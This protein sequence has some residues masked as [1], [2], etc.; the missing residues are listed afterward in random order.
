MRDTYTAVIERALP[1]G[2]SF[3]SE[4]YETGWADEV[5]VFVKVRNG[6]DTERTLQARVQISP[7]GVDW[8][9]FGVDLPPLRG[10]SMTFVT[11]RGFGNWLRVAGTVDAP[12]AE[13]RLSIYL[14]LKG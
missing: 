5:T 2:S 1:V 4:P 6:L 9:D 7:D 10:S 12:D 3:E 14:A 13:V 11:V 8:V